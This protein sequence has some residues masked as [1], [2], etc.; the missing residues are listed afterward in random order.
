[1]AIPKEL[2][3]AILMMPSGEK[4][5][6]LL[7][8]I[9]KDKNLTEQLE[10]KLLEAESTLDQRRDEIKTR[11]ERIA[12]FN[13]ATPGWM[14]MDMRDISGDITKHVKVTKD[15]YGDIELNLTLLNAFFEHQ[16]NLLRVHNSKSDS[17]AEYI[18]KKTHTLIKNLNKLDEDYYVDFEQSVELLLQRVHTYCPKKYAQQLEIPTSW[19]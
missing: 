4:D 15:K 12:K 6:L 2:K 19:P 18:A 13:H 11:I 3:E 1:M 10:Y 8:L 17:V 14:M 5:K 9:S 16:L 7:R